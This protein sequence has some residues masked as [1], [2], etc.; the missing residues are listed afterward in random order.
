MPAGG[1]G[2]TARWGRKPGRVG[3]EPQARIVLARPGRRPGA[4]RMKKAP[5][6]DP[7]AFPYLA[8]RAPG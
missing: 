6:D 8:W 3:R 1:N 7:G 2:V 4:E 5:G